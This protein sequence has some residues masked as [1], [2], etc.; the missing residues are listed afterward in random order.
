M[1]TSLLTLVITLFSIA[2]FAQTPSPSINQP[3]PDVQV[4]PTSTSVRVSTSGLEVSGFPTWIIWVVL[5]VAVVAFVVWYLLLRSEKAEKSKFASG[6]LGVVAVIAVLLLGTYWLSRRNANQELQQAISSRA[7]QSVT[8]SV[9]Q[10]TPLAQASTVPQ[11]GVPASVPVYIV[12]MVF[13][14]LVALE[15]ALFMYIYCRWG[16]FGWRRQGPWD[17]PPDFEDYVLRRLNK[18]ESRMNM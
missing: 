9:P 8:V 17:V 18:I 4:T 16:R 2:I 7:E 10:P 12:L 14:L 5:A 1:R 6:G 15:T 11:V 13:V 3:S